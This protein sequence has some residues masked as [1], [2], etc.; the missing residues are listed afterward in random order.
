MTKVPQA[1]GL[2]APAPLAFFQSSSCLYGIST[3]IKHP[4][5]NSILTKDLV[6]D[7][8]GECF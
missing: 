7:R 1:W 5:D 8:I 4:K 2:A 3:T 6:V